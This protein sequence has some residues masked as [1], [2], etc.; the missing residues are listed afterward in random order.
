MGNVSPLEMLIINGL[1]V[2]PVL[3]IPIETSR[4]HDVNLLL[5]Q[6]MHN[7]QSLSP[8]RLK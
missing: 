7:S 6:F 5:S 4:Q 1:H 2:N 8:G 3:P